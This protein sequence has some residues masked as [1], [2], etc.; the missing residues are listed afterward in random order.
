MIVVDSSIWIDHFRAAI[1]RLIEAALDEQLLQHPFVTIELALGSLRNRDSTIT[2]L[3]KLPQ[4]A[5]VE[6]EAL[7]TFVETNRLQSTGIGLTDA[8]L[9]A[10][11]AATANARLWTRDR[12]L[13]EQAER[14]GLLHVA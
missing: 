3:R 13:A 8:Q 2:D 10:G 4:V 9:L 1:P 14:L 6:V 12:R 7:L 11:T 5:M